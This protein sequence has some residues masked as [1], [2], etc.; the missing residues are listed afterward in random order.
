MSGRRMWP[1]GVTRAGLCYDAA[2]ESTGLADCAGARRGRRVP[3]TLDARLPRL[4]G[5]EMRRYSIV[6]TVERV[7]R[8]PFRL[9]LEAQG[10]TMAEAREDAV[11]RATKMWPSARARAGGGRW[12]K[13]C[14]GEE[15]DRSLSGCG[16]T[17]HA[18]PA[19]V[20]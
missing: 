8:A 20:V 19:T 12:H 5:E 9:R 6:V 18:T 13:D 10:A 4:W 3:G 1:C 14:E 11:K 16:P 2:H 17:L 7:G 15:E